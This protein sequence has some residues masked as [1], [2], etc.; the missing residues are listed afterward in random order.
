MEE[1]ELVYCNTVFLKIF[2]SWCEW[3]GV[4]NMIALNDIRVKLWDKDF[5]KSDD[6]VAQMYRLHTK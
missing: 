3:A 2:M 4:I 1:L 5:L 6:E